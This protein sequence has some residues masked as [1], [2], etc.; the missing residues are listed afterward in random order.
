MLEEVRDAGDAGTLVGAADVGDPSTG[1]AR[2]LVALDQEELEPVGQHL[3]DDGDLLGEGGQRGGDQRERQEE[4]SFHA[5]LC[6]KAPDSPA[7]KRKHIR[8][9]DFAGSAGAT[10]S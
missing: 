7:G 8:S 6:T 4:M 5:R 1:D 9:S 10:R 3:L 2:L